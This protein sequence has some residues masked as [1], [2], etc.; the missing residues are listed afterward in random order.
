M[1]ALAPS[2]MAAS[3]AI[4]LLLGSLHFAYTFRGNKLHPRDA[5]VTARMRDTPLVITRQTTVWK[6][7]IGF[8]ATHS[9]GLML[10]GLVY[11]YLALM[12]TD[13]LFGS[14][15]L[16]ALGLVV[17]VAYAVLARRHFFSVPWRG[18]VLALVLY[19]AAVFAGA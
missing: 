19:G 2:L 15:F 1:P 12:R 18:L 10:F 4:A 8:N 5:S 13:V 16:L 17:L 14:W 7:W 3:A 9:I 11:G 6:A